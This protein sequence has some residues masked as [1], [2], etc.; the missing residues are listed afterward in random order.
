[1]A[2]VVP[3]AAELA[4]GLQRW[5]AFHPE[6]KQDVACVALETAD[7]GLVLIDPLVPPAA[8]AAAA[9]W[10]GLDAVVHELR[11]QVDVVLTLHYHER[12]GPEI[13]DR[14]RGSPGAALWAPAG[15]VSRIAGAPERTFAA[16]DVL[17]GG[18]QTFATGRDDEVVLWLPAQRAV[19]SGDVLLGGVR[20]P[21][22]VCP[23]S[24]LPRGI[25][26]K[27]VAGALAP[28]RELPVELVVPLH[29]DPV[30]AKAAE[31]LV[32]ALDDARA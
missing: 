6:W 12:S 32:A 2:P 25:A 13:V 10:R 30:T 4:P 24:W 3:G 17:P 21:L 11:R 14:Y 20:K 29:G 22:R 28:L 27:D 26:R 7:D 5:V 31:A 18:I 15:S 8:R 9:F 23:A 16:G 19:V 1:M